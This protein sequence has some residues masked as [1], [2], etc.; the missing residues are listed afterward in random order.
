LAFLSPTAFMLAEPGGSTVSNVITLTAPAPDASGNY[1]PGAT[2]DGWVAF[3][4]P[5]AYVDA[6][7]TLVRFL[8]YR[9]ELDERFISFGDDWTDCRR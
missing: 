1:Y 6:G 5:A 8:P 7:T 4:L 2:R 9:G 3:E